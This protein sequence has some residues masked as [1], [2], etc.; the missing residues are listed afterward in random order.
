MPQIKKIAPGDYDSFV[1]IGVNAYPGM[2]INTDEEKKKLKKRIQTIER[3]EKV[4]ATY[5]YYDKKRL[6][7][8]MRLYDFDMT[9]FE[10]RALVG[11]VGFV[12]VDL[13]H[14]KEKI[15]KQMIEYYLDYYLKKGAALTALYPFRP[16][17]YRKMGFGY[18][19]KMNRYRL[20]PA[21]L[22]KGEGKKHIF[23]LSKKDFPAMMRCYDRYA[24]K[25]HG[26]MKKCRFEMMR[27]ETPK[28]KIVGYKKNGKISGYMVFNF[29]SARD[30]NFILNDLQIA[31]LIYENRD[32]FLELISFL[33]SQADQVR[34]IIYSTQDDNFH[35][36]P[37]DPRNFTD[38]Y[39]SPVGHESN[40]QGVGLM[41]RV[42]DIKKLFLML[43]NH[44]FADQTVKLKLSLTDSF[45]KKNAGSYLIQFD[46]GRASLFG[47][48]EFDI[49]ICLDIAE[50]S[51]LIL[52]VVDFKTLYKYKRAEISDIKYLDKVTKLFRVDSKP[53]CTTSF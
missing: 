21:D 50:F 34:Y 40:S 20:R 11:G 8:V 49:E 39:L 35:F 25:T 44:N 28:S 13:L 7:G 18:G 5:G 47:K 31:E 52:G 29:K 6:K 26:M 41:Y 9:L 42:I 4:S 32:V 24:N 36:L 38:N 30:D 23:F 27:F 46:R 1:E 37:F 48:G 12:A 14:K 16:D 33:N 15:C 2:G 10:T 45:L 3:A 53:L 17:F 51:S 19:T 22:P 43:K